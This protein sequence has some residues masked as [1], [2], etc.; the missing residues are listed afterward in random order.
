MNKSSYLYKNQEV[1][2]SQVYK[3]ITTM[4]KMNHN[5]QYEPNGKNEPHSGII[6]N[7]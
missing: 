6:T 7:V 5:H 4:E 3:A 2:L 1:I